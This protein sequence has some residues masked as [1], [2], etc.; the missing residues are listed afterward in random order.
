MTIPALLHFCWIGRTL[1][2]AY[3]FAILSAAEH[4]ELP[5]IVLHH[6]DALDPGGPLDAVAGA[7]GVRLSRLDPAACLART[8]A[9][10]DL[11]DALALLY[12]RLADPVMRSD[13]LRA[14]ILHSNGGLYADL[15]TVTVASL[16][17]LLDTRCL[18]ASER[19]VWP[20]AARTSRSPA[21]LA[22]H[23]SLDLLRKAGRALP[24]GWRPFRRLERLYVRAVSNAVMGAEAGSPA[25]AAYLRA[26]AALPEDGLRGRTALGPRLLAAVIRD[27]A[28][29]A[30]LP[31][32]ATAPL[33]PEI[34]AHWFRPVRRPRPAA[35]LR[36]ETRIVHWYASVR[37]RTRVAAI[38]P[39]W[40]RAHAD[41]QP[42]AALV[43]ASI[44]TLP[45]AGA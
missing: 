22:R 5:E 39:A 13:I 14:A 41:R 20:E 44:R 35:M 27:R 6:T 25:F 3:A 42:Y 33:P 45:A 12:R 16:R 29:V 21:V 17:P 36:P 23:L 10:L 28:D 37:T 40:V 24:H 34:S 11:G 1:P 43:R 4:A 2:W 31:P 26:M 38:D 32:H 30:V 15:D 8:G 19:I 7:P 9:A 18:V